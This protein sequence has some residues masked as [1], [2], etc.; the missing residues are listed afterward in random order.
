AEQRHD[1]TQPAAA[2]GVPDDVRVA[3]HGRF[4]DDMATDF[5]A[6]MLRGVLLPGIERGTRLA[7][8][9]RDRFGWSG[10]H[11]L[12]AARADRPLLVLNSTDT[13][14]G[15]RLAIGFPALPRG[16]L[17]ETMSA[18]ADVAPGWQ[19]DLAQAVRL[20][21]NFPWG[22]QVAELDTGEPAAP[23]PPWVP[24]LARGYQ[25]RHA[26]ELGDRS[27]I[28]VLDGGLIDNTGI[29]TVARVF[30]RLR[31][32]EAGHG[33]APTDGQPWT[34]EQRQQVERL[35][36]GAVTV[37]HE[38]RRRKV[39]LIEIDAGRKFQTDGALSR[40]L[41]T[42]FSPLSSLEAAAHVNALLR[43]EA[44]M[45]TLAD[46][47]DG[48]VDQKDRIARFASVPFVCNRDDDVMTAWALGSQDKA[49]VMVQFLTESRMQ[50]EVLRSTFA[51]LAGGTKRE[52]LSR[53]QDE[54]DAEA[55]VRQERYDVRQ[56]QAPPP[57]APPP[58]AKEVKQRV[59]PRGIEWK[60]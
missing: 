36:A 15:V 37:L 33:R 13:G 27:Q 54:I 58:A 49:S 26:W 50:A 7:D 19:V 44:H 4:A 17:G 40:W 23:P 2:D 9:W 57:S 46:V 20:S 41:P 28:K 31:Q 39:L 53:K 30:E 14:R 5:M 32:I 56:Q 55:M 47:L 24:P 11:N 18:L 29:D 59:H 10:V 6:P 25:A 48:E 43:K 8:F 52:A 38:L 12:G 16:L 34:P 42:L 22:L 21:A 60:K 51:S 45:R 1:D 35:Q 3:V